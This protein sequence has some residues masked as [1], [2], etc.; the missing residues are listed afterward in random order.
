[1]AKY[2]I[3]RAC[4]CVETLQLYGPH[5]TRERKIEYFETQ[6]CWECEKKALTSAAKASCA[7]MPALEGTE[8]QIAWAETLRASRKKEIDMFRARLYSGHP[9]A[10]EALAALDAVMAPTEAKYWIETRHDSTETLI[11]KHFVE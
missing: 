4:G 9:R 1:M 5:V 2:Q 7:D 11:R 6:N 3:T 8:K 10:T